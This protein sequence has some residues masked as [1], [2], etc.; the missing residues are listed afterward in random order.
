MQHRSFVFC[1]TGALICVAMT[2]CGGSSPPA[3]SPDPADEAALAEPSESGNKTTAGHGVEVGMEFEDKG[4]TS[5]KRDRTPPPT[6]TYKPSNKGKQ[7]A[8]TP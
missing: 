2:A 5:E 6:P 8:V 4:D 3:N 7:A 1:A